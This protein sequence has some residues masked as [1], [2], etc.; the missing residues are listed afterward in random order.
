[1][2][3]G[4]TGPYH[5]SLVLIN[6]GRT[7]TAPSSLS[8]VNPLP[9]HNATIVLDNYFGREFN[10]VNDGKIHRQSGKI[11]FTDVTYGYL[12]GFRDPPRMKN[13]V[14]SFDPTTGHVRVATDA[15]VRPNGIAFS[16]DGKTAYVG[17]TG[18]AAGSLGR[19]QT[20]P[21][22]IYAFDVDP[23]SHVFTNRRVFA[24]I[25]AAVPDG[26]QVDTIGN[27]YSSCGDGVHVWSRDGTL[28]GKIFIGHVSA[29]L[30]FA[31]RGKLVI[32]GSHT[33]YLAQIAAEGISVAYP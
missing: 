19:D 26:I 5:S 17:D 14:Y 8:L 28:I 16:Q 27:V 29:N 2:T 30:A 13:Q 22:T 20:M 9:P 6:M 1:M 33:L 32:L 18:A 21:A 31:G 23:R 7:G 25:D 3:W 4:A 11:F 15:V 12:K 24:F 10:S